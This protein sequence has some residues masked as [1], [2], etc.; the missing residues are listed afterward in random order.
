MERNFKILFSSIV[1]DLLFQLR[2]RVRLPSYI[3]SLFA[4]GFTVFSTPPDVVIVNDFKPISEGKTAMPTRAAKKLTFYFKSEKNT[5]FV[6]L[7]FG[8]LQS[9]LRGRRRKS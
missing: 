4:A 1:K 6:S 8:I 7:L 5:T 2:N 9:V 3:F